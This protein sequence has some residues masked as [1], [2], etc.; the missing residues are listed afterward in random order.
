MSQRFFDFCYDQYKEE[1]REAE[2]LYQ[3]A[4]VMLVV[5]PLLCAV[6]VKLGRIDI[7]DIAFARA[8]VFLYYLGSAVALMALATSTVFLLRCV[9]P[10]RYE[11]LASM[12]VWEEW[13]GSYEEY[14]R[15]NK[16][17]SEDDGGAALNAGTLAN[18][19]TQLVKAQPVNAELNENRRRAFKQSVKMAAIAL[20]AVGLQ[21]LFALVLRVQGV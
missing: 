18:L 17:S 7:F 19:R 20:A 5:I 12:N 11:T 1:M 8:D 14:L 13:R 16:E 10:R 2:G 4:G 3:R 15:E 6:T 9:Y 21:A